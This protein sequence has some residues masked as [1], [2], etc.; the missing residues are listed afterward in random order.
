MHRPTTRLTRAASTLA[1]GVAAT[2]VVGFLPGSAHAAGQGG[3]H[4]SVRARIVQM[5]HRMTLQ[6]KVGQ[7]FITYAYGDSADTTDPADVAANQKVY[8]VDNAKQLIDK[9]HLG[10]IIYYSWSDNVNSPRQIARLSNGIQRAATS[11]RVPVPALVATDQEG[12]IVA[13]VGP[14]ATQLP[15]NMALGAGRSTD[16]AYAA[17]HITGEELKAIGI[18][19]DYAPVSDVNV[20][21]RNPVIGVRSF[22]SD[23]Q[24]VANMAAA[25]VDGYQDAGIAATAKHFPG[26]GD[27]DVDSHTGIPIIHHTREQWRQIDMPPFKADIEHGIDAI[28]TAHIEVPS[29]DP[30]GDPATL[31]KPIIT[32]I[33]RHKLHFDGV[34]VT[35][36][37]DM[38]GVREKYGDARVPV[39]A[40]KAGVD[41]LLKPPDGG[42]DLQYHAVI[43]AVKSGELK[44]H[45][46]NQAVARILR[47]KFK[48]GLFKDPYVDV[49]K[50][51][52]VVGTPQHLSKA[53]RITDKTV[54]LVKNDAELLPLSADQRRDVLVTGWGSGTTRTLAGDIRAKGQDVD[55]YYTG[56]PT[57]AEIAAA[58][59]KGKAHD[60]TVVTTSRAWDDAQQ[61][62]LV[63][64]LVAA[65]KPVIAVAV[66]DPYDIASFTDAKTYLTTYSYGAVA[67][68]SLTGVL[69]GEVE[70]R[71]KLPVMI[72]KAGTQDEVLYPFGYGLSYGS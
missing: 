58:V 66:R 63:R 34:V 31:S 65:G 18:N 43:D 3:E 70:P 35:D 21:P 26:H 51:D 7:L 62:R 2:L 67:L 61:A 60:L 23:P 55:R 30:S 28:M 52:D 5:I 56:S 33:L 10:G 32:G 71:G 36:A 38:A 8:G 4:R 13:R 42:L 20:N 46:I 11:Q 49:S 29:L 16:D 39:L 40:L 59:E 72:P 50:V 6:E 22:G 24:L 9:Y 17:A 53:Q 37:L 69:F 14:P 48:I 68:T 57:D 54:T 12:G 15:G 1:A 41:M 47:L 44:M 25:Q 64:K 45:R 19:Q 27:T